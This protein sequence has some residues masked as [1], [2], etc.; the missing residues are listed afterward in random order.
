MFCERG[1][2]QVRLVILNLRDH[3]AWAGIQSIG[4]ADNPV[5]GQGKKS[6]IT[7]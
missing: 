7:D 6:L 5:A 2:A 3:E 4:I 1:S